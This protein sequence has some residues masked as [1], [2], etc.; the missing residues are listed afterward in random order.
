MDMLIYAHIRKS[1][2]HLVGSEI[3]IRESMI[4]KKKLATMQNFITSNY[5]TIMN[6]INCGPKWKQSNILTYL[7][8]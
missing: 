3:R 8:N 5:H 6:G 2:T 7:A 4:L 1:Q